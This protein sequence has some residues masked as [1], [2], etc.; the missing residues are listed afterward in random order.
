MQREDSPTLPLIN[1]GLLKSQHGH[2]GSS[3]PH[4][5]RARP[6]AGVWAWAHP[7]RGCPAGDGAAGDRAPGAGWA[8]TRGQ[9]AGDG[10]ALAVRG[11]RQQQHG[12]PRRPLGLPVRASPRLAPRLH[13]RAPARGDGPQALP[14]WRFR[15]AD[16]RPTHAC[17]R[18][19]AGRPLPLRTLSRLETR[20]A[21]ERFRGCS[22][23][24]RGRIAFLSPGQEVENNFEKELEARCQPGR[25]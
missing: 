23:P 5:S 15:G 6:G 8:P 3:R 7:N 13:A 12:G 11:A 22:V 24:A 4:A 2:R 18:R 14:G 20:S 19:R 25:L 17:A 1:R 21:K 9:S 16:A 10:G